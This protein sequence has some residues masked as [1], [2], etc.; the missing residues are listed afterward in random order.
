MTIN[1]QK[2]R[3]NLGQP[4]VIEIK[5]VQKEGCDFPLDPDDD[6]VIKAMKNTDAELQ[7]MHVTYIK[8]LAG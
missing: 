6:L 1:G 3:F 7:K 2:A 8:S 4:S 5:K